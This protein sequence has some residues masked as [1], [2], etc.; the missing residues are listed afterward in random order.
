VPA[1]DRFIR[2]TRMLLSVS[3]RFMQETSAGLVLSVLRGAAAGITGGLEEWCRAN[4]LSWQSRRKYV[5]GA[6]PEYLTLYL[7]R[8]DTVSFSIYTRKGAGPT[9]AVSG[10]AVQVQQTGVYTF[11][12]SPAA[13]SAIAAV[14]EGAHIA[15]YDVEAAGGA[16]MQYVLD[17]PRSE[18]ERWFLWENSLG[19]IDTMRMFGDEA[20]VLASEDKTIERK[21]VTTTYDVESS[22]TWRQDTGTLSL[23]ER[24][25]LLD[26]FRSPNRYVFRGGVLYPIVLTEAGGEG[27]TSDNVSNYTFTYRLSDDKG[28]LNVSLL[29]DTPPS[30]VLPPVDLSDFLLPP[31]PSNLEPL[32]PGEGV[33]FPAL[34][35]N[36]WGVIGYNQ[37][38]SGLQSGL[39]HYIDKLIKDYTAWYLSQSGM[40]SSSHLSLL[41]SLSAQLKALREQKEQL[42]GLVLDV[43]K[44]ALTNADNSAQ[45][46]LDALRAHL[47]NHTL[48]ESANDLILAVEDAFA[49]YSKV[50]YIAQKSLTDKLTDQMLQ[51]LAQMGEDC[52]AT[53]LGYAN[54]A[55]QE[56]FNQAQ[57]YTNLTAVTLDQSITATQSLEIFIRSSEGI[58]MQQ[59]PTSTM[60]VGVRLNG[61]DITDKVLAMV[62]AVNFVWHRKSKTGVHES[63]TDAEWDAYALGRHEVTFKRAL[64]HKLR[65]W[66]ETST[67]DDARIIEQF[68]Y[69]RQ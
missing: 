68:K 59:E 4:P 27:L 17:L 33:L 58:L 67:E 46:A 9:K 1:G 24:T 14:E 65:F 54:A 63:M 35:N 21:D 30:L 44:V 57:A 20:V 51:Q 38:M 29:N 41:A 23:R 43:V 69:K 37:L 5:L 7:K 10:Q 22:R 8:N 12:V 39:Q 64:K 34:F 18:D 3:V 55:Q 6:Q 2:Q 40:Q 42:V 48:D 25:W 66:L 53:A 28:G 31:H 16:K 50:I 56:A 19:G 26:F 32:S 47:E 49:R 13:M 62:P 60:S 52:N 11:D 36:T 61:K 45:E 15:Y